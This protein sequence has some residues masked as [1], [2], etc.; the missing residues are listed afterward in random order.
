MNMKAAAPGPLL[1][2]EKASEKLLGVLR[3]KKKTYLPKWKVIAARRRA[4][5]H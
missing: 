3:G 1:E 2:I 5:V 4:G